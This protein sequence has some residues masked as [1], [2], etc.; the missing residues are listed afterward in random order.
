M[1]FE[2]RPTSGMKSKNEISNKIEIKMKDCIPAN[3]LLEKQMES[4]LNKTDSLG[5]ITLSNLFFL[6]PIFES[7]QE[8]KSILIR[9]GGNRM[10]TALSDGNKH[11]INTNLAVSPINLY[12]F[13][14]IIYIVCFNSPIISETR[15]YFT[16]KYTYR[17]KEPQ[18]ISHDSIDRNAY[19]QLGTDKYLVFK[20]GIAYP[21]D[22]VELKL[23]AKFSKNAQK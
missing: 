21:L 20:G 19:Q 6:N 2:E 11:V 5:H 1:K 12:C 14:E 4:Y 23:T 18:I 13:H 15:L 7:N 17:S 9:I 22:T 3:N 8:I 16:S 10:K